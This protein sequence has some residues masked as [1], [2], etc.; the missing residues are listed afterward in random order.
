MA[1]NIITSKDQND[2]IK[3]LCNKIEQLSNQAIK[4]R[5]RFTIG[6][7]GGSLIDFLAA[8]LPGI[9]TDW[10]KWLFI[11]CD[12]RIVPENDKES[13]AGQYKSKL[14]TKIQ[15]TPSQFLTI[16]PNLLPSS[17]ADSYSNKLKQL[18][19]NDPLPKID[20][21]LLGLG[22][23]GHTC[24]LFP[25]HPALSVTNKWVVGIDDSPKMPPQRI[26]L[27]Y[28]VINNARSC[29]FVVAGKGKAETVKRIVKDG[30]DFPAGMV[31]PVG[32]AVWMLDEEA[33]SLLK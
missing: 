18:F 7:S 31:K 8:G 2:L 29:I 26:T 24:S 22:P 28:D 12:E 9:N 20:L 4:D 16:D 30:E 10:T 25:G 17:C 6:L 3:S 15:I 32:G 33:G 13:T 23:D 19:P 27:T 5:S 14:F 21:L 11:L 1:G